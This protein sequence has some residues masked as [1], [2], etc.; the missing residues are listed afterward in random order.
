MTRP[1]FVPDLLAG[2]VAVVTGGASGIGLGIATALAAH[3]ADVVI[4]GRQQDRLSAAVKVIGDRTGRTCLDAVCDVRD[5][6]AVERMRDLVLD[7]H[8]TVT[9]VVN[10]AAA[11]FAMDAARMTRRAFE[12]VVDVDLI[13]TFAV[14]RAFVG[15]L[16]ADGGGSVLNI[17]IPE[18]ERGFPHYAHCA[19]A[20]AGIVSLTRTWAR[21]WGPHGIRVNA[22][23]PGTVPGTGAD[24]TMPGLRDLSGAHSV[25]RIPLG[26]AGTPED[27]AAAAVFLCS[28][29]A[30]WIS[31]AVLP[32][33]GGTGTSA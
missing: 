22:I 27:I 2:D 10:N 13:G 32:V 11:N 28:R 9:T 3:G 24:D 19:A 23:A 20:K 33:D 17:V 4:V 14:T 31:G 15:D 12:T 7:Q 5:E 6:S 8:G 29:A 26:R 1:A 18:P 25:D 16:L 21:E 30:S